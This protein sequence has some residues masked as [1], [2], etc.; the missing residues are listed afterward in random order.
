V[1]ELVVDQVLLQEITVDHQE[2]IQFLQEVHLSL[3]QVVVEQVIVQWLELLADRAAVVELLI[4][5][6]KVEQVMPEVFQSLKEIMEVQVGQYQ[7]HLT[8]VA[9]VVEQVLLEHVHLNLPVNQVV[10][11]EQVQ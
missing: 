9:V 3:Q 11:V 5:D 1:V 2:Q 8:M 10:M 4:L 6:L 7:E